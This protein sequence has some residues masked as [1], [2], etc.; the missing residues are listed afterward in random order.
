MD[1]GA[2][3]LDSEDRVI[4]LKLYLPGNDEVRS[5]GPQT[6]QR[7]NHPAISV[8]FY[9]GTDKDRNALRAAW[10]NEMLRNGG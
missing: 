10:W 3:R 7:Q 9:M 1:W 4:A 8:S 5:P 6:S 2:N